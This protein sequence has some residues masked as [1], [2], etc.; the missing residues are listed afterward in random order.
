M[1]WSKRTPEASTDDRIRPKATQANG[2]L[3][4]HEHA[5]G[6]DLASLMPRTAEPDVTRPMTPSAINQKSQLAANPAA[7]RSRHRRG[8]LLR[9]A[10]D[11][12]NQQAPVTAGFDV[13]RGYKRTAQ[14]ECYRRTS[15]ESVV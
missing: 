9:S 7:S 13:G 2:K 12:G 15:A 4:R 6:A 14:V 11:D 3:K 8:T 10:Y 1:R 5:Q